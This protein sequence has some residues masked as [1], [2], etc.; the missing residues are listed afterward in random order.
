MNHISLKIHMV[1]DQINRHLMQLEQLE[2]DALIRHDYLMSF[3]RLHSKER[4]V[5]LYIKR[6]LKTTML[7]PNGTVAE[8]TK[9]TS[10]GVVISL[11]L[12]NLFMH[13]A[14]DRWITREFP[15][16]KWERYADDGLIHCVSKK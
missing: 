11:L 14:L 16:C 15:M 6:C 4:W 2:K 7:M 12:A 10:Q 8:R 1:I 5:N 3:V 9:G 13:Y